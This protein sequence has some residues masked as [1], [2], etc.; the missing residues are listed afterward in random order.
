MPDLHPGGRFPIGAAFAAD[1]ELFPF[2]VGSDVG[3][4]MSLFQTGLRDKGSKRAKKWSEQL[5]SMEGPWSGN[6]STFLADHG[7]ETLVHT[8]KSV[9][10]PYRNPKPVTPN[11]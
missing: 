10:K 7:K 4:G 9:Q 6:A 8:L 1:G 5:Q 11:Q 2:L 3:C